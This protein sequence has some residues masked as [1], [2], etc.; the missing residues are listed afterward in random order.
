MRLRME[1][2]LAGIDIGTT[3]TKM[4]VYNEIGAELAH[5]SYSYPNRSVHS[6]PA[7]SIWDAVLNCI[8][9]ITKQL[10]PGDR[11]DAL[12]VSS[13]GESLVA[14]DPS[15]SCWRCILKGEHFFNLHFK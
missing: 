2:K 13:F 5:A 10:S 12:A 15:S 7:D 11:I 14:I 9:A 8:S 3:N 1:K 6:I 4:T